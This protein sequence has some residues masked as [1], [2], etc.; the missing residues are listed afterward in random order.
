M[1]LT[2]SKHEN[3]VNVAGPSGVALDGYD[4]VAFF[5]DKRPVNG[6]HN[7]SADYKGATYY[8]ASEEHKSM[9]ERDPEKYVPQFGGFCA[10][11]VSKGGLFPVDVNTWQIIDGKLY[12]N[13]NPSMQAEFNKG[14]DEKIRKAEE[15]W[16]GLVKHNK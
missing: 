16:P 14:T 9:F 4:P 12:L 5:T 10:F 3:L 13:L 7:I 1:V 11:G 6:D 15:N 2:K 8:F